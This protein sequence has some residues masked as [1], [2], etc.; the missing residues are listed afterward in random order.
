MTSRAITGRDRP[1]N[2]ASTEVRAQRAVVPDPALLTPPVAAAPEGPPAA[3]QKLLAEHHRSRPAAGGAKLTAHPT[4]VAAVDP[5]LALAGLDPTTARVAQSIRE[6][7]R[8]PSVGGTDSPAAICQALMA[9]LAAA[10]LRA[11]LLI[12]PTGAPAGV[13]SEIVGAEPGPRYVLDAV[14]DTAPIGDPSTWSVDPLSAEV[15]DGKMLGRG[16]ADS[17][18]SAAL[19]IELGR[20]L[21]ARTADMAGST[22]LF[23]DAAEHTGEFQGIKAL[24]AR[25]PQ[26]DGVM[27]GYPGADVLNIGSRGFF[28]AHLTATL[29][30]PGD[31]RA[32]AQAL[33][34]PTTAALP[35]ETTAEFALP[36]KL[37]LTAVRTSGH[38]RVGDADT[39]ARALS[40]RLTGVASHSGSSK[41]S[42][43]NA[44]LKAARVLEVLDEVVRGRFGDAARVQ[45][46]SVSGGREFSQVP[47][48]VD[49]RIAITGAGAN[50][51]AV[52]RLVERAL[53]A[54]DKELPSPKPSQIT[55][56]S[57]V[58]GPI[59]RASS[60]VSN[61]DMRT[62]PA[63]GTEQARAHLT[64]AVGDTSGARIALEAREAWAPF[65]LAKDS[66]LR[67]AL[68]AG[69][70]AS[71]GHTIPSVVSG[72]SNV[73]NLLASY[74]IP[75][76]TGYGVE[77]QGVHAADEAIVLASIPRALD[78][79]R[80]AIHG[81]MGL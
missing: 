32:I 45:V 52:E 54:V 61:V 64:A 44:A 43:S 69:V 42:G 25:H 31:P 20:E 73:G 47:D 13:I 15:K 3:A 9:Q 2:V 21:H 19:F 36:P 34:A 14:V 78:V 49:L 12:D 30:E 53:A 67:A 68:E 27:I 11:E 7:V 26:L 74:G 17:K 4:Q 29:A 75:A 81:L 46:S 79:Y 28:R 65:V 1:T 50:A 59:E 58:H 18:A 40:L 37:T 72:P 66:P 24:L 5:S 35:T 77:F 76:T 62:T 70:T 33:R 56:Q 60:I 80:R 71:T 23:F 22:V 57:T 10:G 55:E 39:R 38:T 51:N 6:L 16:V 8:I 48:A 63:F 41:P